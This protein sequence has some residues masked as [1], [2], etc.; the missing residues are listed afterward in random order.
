MVIGGAHGP[1]HGPPLKVTA[2][3][4][5][6]T[7]G[8]FVLTHMMRGYPMNVGPSVGIKVGEVDVVLTSKPQQTFDTEIFRL[9]GIDTSQCSVVGLKSSA[10]FRAGFNDIASQILTADSPGLTTLNVK[11]FDHSKHPEPIWPIDATLE[12]NA[13]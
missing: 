6:I 7:D 3:I 10:H 5:T 1:L 2:T 12:W 11:N 8:R 4:R 13:Q 9:H